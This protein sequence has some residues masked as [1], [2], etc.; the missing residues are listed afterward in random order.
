MPILLAALALSC[1]LIGA[2]SGN[3]YTDILLCTAGVLL[4]FAA[5]KADMQN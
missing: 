2:I 4:L 5:M 3:I 1:V